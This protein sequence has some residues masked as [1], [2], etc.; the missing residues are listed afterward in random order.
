MGLSDMLL[1]VWC[2]G[3]ARDGMDEVSFHEYMGDLLGGLRPHRLLIF[4]YYLWKS[5]TH[6]T[7]CG[8]LPVSSMMS[9]LP[10]GN[11]RSCRSAL[12]G[13]AWRGSVLGRTRSVFNCTG[14]CRGRA[15]TAR[16]LGGGGRKH[17]TN[18]MAC[19]HCNSFDKESFQ[20]GFFSWRMFCM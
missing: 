13:K 18:S 10:C 7:G 1:V 4:M 16:G 6:P 9:T 12:G 8:S 14:N 2:S 3:K 19:N 17:F 5:F 20:A 11:G 15:T